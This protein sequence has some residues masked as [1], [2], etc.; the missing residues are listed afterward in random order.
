MKILLAHIIVTILLLGSSAGAE[1]MMTYYNKKQHYAIIYPASWKISSDPNY[2]QVDALDVSSPRGNI[3]LNVT[4]RM[5]DRQLR[6]QI[7]SLAEIPVS[8]YAQAIIEDLK[9][10]NIGLVNYDYGRTTLFNC[11]AVWI[12]GNFLIRSL[13]NDTWF[14]V[15]MISALKNDRMYHIN[16]KTAGSS[17]DAANRLFDEKWQLIS[18][19][20]T[21]FT[22]TR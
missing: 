22:L 6:G 14:S 17:I 3:N 9:Q 20:L 8:E 11:D 19:M 13:N 1:E 4:V 12:K 5:L 15:Y 18:S 7:K 21:S 16:A 10:G 2:Y